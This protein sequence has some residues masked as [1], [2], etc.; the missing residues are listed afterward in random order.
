MEV[1]LR[2]GFISQS[3]L[4]DR[5]SHSTSLD[6]VPDADDRIDQDD[7]HCP[8]HGLLPPESQVGTELHRGQ[9]ADQQD[10]HQLKPE[11]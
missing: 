5:D 8:N 2:Q 4:A 7:P 11:T 10:C 6:N 1:A 9:S 3:R